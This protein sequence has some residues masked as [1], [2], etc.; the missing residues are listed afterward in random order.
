[1]LLYWLEDRLDRVRLVPRRITERRD[2]PVNGFWPRLARTIMRRP[3][4]FAAAT[5]VALL[6][7]AA[8]LLALQL[9]PGS[10]QGIP[11]DLQAVQGL[12]ILT[13]AVG[14]GALSPTEVV[15][16]TGRAGGGSDPQVQAA[17][18]RLI[19]GLEADPEIAQVSYGNG[20]QFR[21]PTGR[22]LHLQATGRHEYGLPEAQRVRRPAA[23]RHRP[24]RGVPGR[25]RR[26]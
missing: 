3:A 24:G 17:V 1:M 12:N 26:C 13:D 21:D 9:G 16:D 10:N 23:R 2:D 22:Y 4:A 18:G 5:T 20:P 11:Q 25:R 8:P 6:L 7:A 14:E 15:V 19:A